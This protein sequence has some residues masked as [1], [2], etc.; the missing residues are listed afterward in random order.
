MR[1]AHPRDLPSRSGG[2]QASNFEGGVRGE[3]VP[4]RGGVLGE[5]Q[6]RVFGNT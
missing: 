2:P 3:L 1:A 5:G 4:V 6:V